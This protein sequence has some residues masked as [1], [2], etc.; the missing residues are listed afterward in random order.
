MSKELDKLIDKA[1]KKFPKIAQEA[2]Y[3]GQLKKIPLD[4]PQMSYMFGGG[5]AIGRMHRFRGPESSG[6]S[7]ICN[8]LAGQLQRKL[9]G[10][11]FPN[12]Y[13]INENKKVVIYIDFERSFDIKHAT[14]NGMLCDSDHLIHLT[15][16]TIE[17][18][19]D[20]IEPLIKTDEIVAVIMDSDA[21]IATR[22]SLTDPAGKANF[23][24][25]AKAASEFLCKYNI[26]CANYDTT[27]FWISQERVNMTP[28]S[29]LPNCTGGEAPKYYAST[30]NR[31]TKTDVIKDA[32]DTLGIAI[33]LRNYK[34]KT[35]GPP[36]RDANVKLYY[37]GG[38]NPDEEYIDFLIAFE[39]VKQKGAY[40]YVDG[41]EKSIQGR[42]KLQEWLNAHIDLYT[43]MKKKVDSMLSS[44]TVLDKNNQE[45][46]ESV[47]Y[48]QDEITE[49]ILKEQEDNEG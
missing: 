38:F 43:E 26:L 23:G 18:A 6:K 29:H 5:L 19:S 41:L 12:D 49:D 7:T 47:D 27:I 9:P 34:N 2:K 31:T 44:T 16:D 25:K 21:A 28:M 4:S 8:Y 22:A 1:L 30:V 17:D 11:V 46:S 14:E 3:A 40:F 36:F 10:Y 15:P 32:D 24:A 35:G 42:Q 39:I 13:S 48:T 37:K 20:V 33:R 45:V